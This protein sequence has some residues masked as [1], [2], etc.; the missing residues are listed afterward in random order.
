LHF[1]FQQLLQNANADDANNLIFKK[2]P[3]KTL[4]QSKLKCFQEGKT[5][6]EKKFV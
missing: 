1:D 4:A 2:R 3:R 5:V 6:M